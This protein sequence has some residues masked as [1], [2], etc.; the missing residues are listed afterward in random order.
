MKVLVTGG[1][2]FIGK[3]VCRELEHRGFEPAVFDKST[4]QDVTDAV[5][6]KEAMY[7]CRAAIHLAGVLGT[8]EL[9]ETP[10]KAVD[11]NIHGTL[12]V[13][14][15]VH[16]VKG[17]YVGITMPESR[18][19]NVYQATKH[20]AVRLA[21]AWHQTYGLSVSH[22]RAFNAYGP[23][24]KWGE[25]HPRKIVPDF[26]VRGWTGNPIEVWGN[27]QQTVDLVHTDDLARML[28]DAMAFGDDQVFDGGTGIAL[29]VSDVA[30][31]VRKVTGNRSEIVH[32][33]MRPG[34]TPDT[35][36]RAEGEGW[37]DLR[38]SPK[39]DEQKL[40]EAVNWYRGEYA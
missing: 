39:H 25:G 24:Q 22:V 9:F 12:N 32:L 20:A 27:G 34:E 11:V 31:L 7:G 18:W 14:Q 36:I 17:A 1:S 35:N 19:R 4:G 2:G 37:D 30:E 6:V 26:S 16:A 13:L 3:A 15:A 29:T 33:P 10:H 28:V 40:I 5:A 38:W 23:G 8:A 21:S